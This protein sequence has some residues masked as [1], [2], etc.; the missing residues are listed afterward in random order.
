MSPLKDTVTSRTAAGPGSNATADGRTRASHLPSVSYSTAMTDY[1]RIARAIDFLSGH[2]TEQPT[3]AALAAHL[4]LSPFHLQRLFS[5]WAGTSPKRFL[6]VMTLELGKQLLDDA[7]PVLAASTAAGLSSPSRLYDHFVQLEGVTPGEYRRRGEG[8]RIDHGVSDTPYGPLFLAATPRGIC[9]AS[10]ADTV[11]GETALRALQ[12]QWPGALLH[13][14][15]GLAESLARRIF[16]ASGQQAE[17]QET[18]GAADVPSLHVQGTNF[19]L[20]VWRALLS[21]PA[22]RGVSYRQVAEAIGRPRASRAVGSAVGA[23]P[24]AILIPCHRVIRE[25]GALGG[26]RWSPERKLAI[27][28]RERILAGKPA[29][30]GGDDTTADDRIAESVVT[31]PEN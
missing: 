15:H 22:G 10:F 3:L 2:V 9:M 11:P 29:G 18:A 21:I 24:V 13:E 1:E 5:R 14:N 17:G 7:W 26:Y 6:Q 30:A 8:L 28:A 19:Q 12:D 16:A 31:H 25:S 4:H 20:A 23:N 27:Q